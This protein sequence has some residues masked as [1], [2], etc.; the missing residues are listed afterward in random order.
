MWGG[1]GGEG[2]IEGRPGKRVMHNSS[3]V[4]ANTVNRR[5]K[6]PA[7]NPLLPPPPP[8]ICTGRGH[9]FSFTSDAGQRGAKEEDKAAGPK[10]A[11]SGAI[12]GSEYDLRRLSIKQC[13]CG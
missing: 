8:H 2:R 12:T 1:E 10:A 5:T 3:A 11:E 9:G 7:L 4:M 13:R 6:R